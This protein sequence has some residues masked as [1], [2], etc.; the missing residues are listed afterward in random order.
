MAQGYSLRCCTLSKF[1]L[2]TL[3]LDLTLWQYILLPFVF[4]CKKIYYFRFSQS[5]FKR[6]RTCLTKGGGI[7]HFPNL[8]PI[9]SRNLSA[10]VCFYCT[11]NVAIYILDKKVMDSFGIRQGILYFQNRCHYP[12]YASRDNGLSKSLYTIHTLCMS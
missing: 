6:L 7:V 4:K 8:C 11:L 2:E 9:H 5:W 10:M 1:P 3:L 12:R